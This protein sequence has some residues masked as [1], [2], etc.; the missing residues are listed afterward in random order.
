MMLGIVAKLTVQNVRILDT[1]VFHM[2]PN[3]MAKMRREKWLYDHPR[4]IKP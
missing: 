2:I 1:D 3:E 4:K